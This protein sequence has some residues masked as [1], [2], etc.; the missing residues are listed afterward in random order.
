MPTASYVK[1]A[2]ANE[3]LAESAHCGTDQWAIALTNTVPAG[4]TFTA[5]R[6]LIT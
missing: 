5:L 6:A 2:A 1:I 3:D 4:K